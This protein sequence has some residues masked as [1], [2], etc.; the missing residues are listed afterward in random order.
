MSGQP[1]YGT[2]PG[3]GYPP[4]G[5][6]YPPPGGYQQGGYPPPADKTKVLNLAYNVAGMLC[7]L[8]SCLC[9][10]NLIS[11]VLWL[12]T[13]PKESHFVRFHALQGLMLWGTGFV[14]GIIF[15]ILGAGVRWGAYMGSGGSDVASAGAGGLIGILYWVIVVVFFILHIVAAVKAYQGEKWKLPVIGDIAEKNS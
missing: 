8:P 4:P 7:Y 9:C 13:E 3:G 2:P 15:N 5:G 1:P 14:I 11:A 6:G 12:V 10:I